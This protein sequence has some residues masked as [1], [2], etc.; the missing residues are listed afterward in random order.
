MMRRPIPSLRRARLPQS[1]P[2]RPKA[3]ARHL[4]G[5]AAN[6]RSH[7]R[8]RISGRPWSGYWLVSHPPIGRW[9]HRRNCSSH[10]LLLN[11]ISFIGIENTFNIPLHDTR[12]V[13]KQLY[14]D[15]AFMMGTFALYLQFC[16]G[17]TAEGV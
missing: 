12:L 9:P 14:F 13:E 11:C 5:C 2:S 7:G 8:A 3:H 16:P 10:L 15:Q 1:T 4:S 17:V 6:G